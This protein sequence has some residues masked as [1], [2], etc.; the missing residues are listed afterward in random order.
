MENWNK[1]LK[2]LFLIWFGCIVWRSCQLHFYVQP[3]TEIDWCLFVP[4]IAQIW[5]DLPLWHFVFRDGKP[6]FV[7]WENYLPLLKKTARV[8]CCPQIHSFCLAK[9]WGFYSVLDMD[10]FLSLYT[11]STY[12]CFSGQR[13]TAYKTLF[14]LISALTFC[15]GVLLSKADLPDW[16]FLLLCGKDTVQIILF[17]FFKL[18]SSSNCLLKTSLLY[19]RLFACSF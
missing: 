14:F 6:V 5:G 4:I 1:S 10:L 11:T 9:W 12:C 8:S 3:F 15:L 2:I 7:C 17:F 18:T 16:V 19:T 13:V